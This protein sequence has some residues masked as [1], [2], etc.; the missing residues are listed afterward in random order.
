MQYPTYRRRGFPLGSGAIEGTCKHV[1]IDRLRLSGM[2]W[3]L[4]TAE[5]VLQLRTALLT[6]P[7]IDLRNYA[8]HKYTPAG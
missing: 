1:V 6:Q 7:R 5:P 3:K 4:D 2:R 8:R